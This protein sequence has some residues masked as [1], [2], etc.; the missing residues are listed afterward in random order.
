MFTINPPLKLRSNA[1]LV[2]PTRTIQVWFNIPAQISPI[3]PEGVAGI[4]VKLNGNVINVPL[5][6]EYWKL[7]VS[8]D[9]SSRPWLRFNDGVEGE[10]VFEYIYRNQWGWLEK[11]IGQR[12]GG[13]FVPKIVNAA[14]GDWV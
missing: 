10:F 12:F 1:V 6:S 4:G 5:Q 7:P 9:L 14:P 8:V 11:M 2:F 3:T 13:T